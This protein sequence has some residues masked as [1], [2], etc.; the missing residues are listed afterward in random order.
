[1]NV[2][3]AASMNGMTISVTM[4]SSGI[5]AISGVLT[6]MITMYGEP[7]AGDMGGMTADGDGGG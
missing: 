7:E 4:M 1:M 3:T 5:I 6:G 2:M